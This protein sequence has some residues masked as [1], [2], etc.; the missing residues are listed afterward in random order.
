MARPFLAEGIGLLL[1]L[2]DEGHLEHRRYAI[3]NRLR[4]LHDSEDFASLPEDLR[5]RIREITGDFSH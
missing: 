3:V 4:R 1:S 2:L 5:E